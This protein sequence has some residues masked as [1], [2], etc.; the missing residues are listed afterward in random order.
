MEELN[1]FSF[2]KIGESNY[3]DIQKLFL[4]VYGLGPSLS[5]IVEKFNCLSGSLASIGYVAY[6]KVDGVLAALYAIFPAEC[7]VDGTK[8]LC[9][10]SGDTMTHPKYRGN[11]LFTALAK[12]TYLEARLA[13]IKFIFG[14]PNENSYYGFKTKLAWTFPKKTKSSLLPSVNIFRS[15][16]SLNISAPRVKQALSTFF[17]VKT[18]AESV[19][20]FC[21]QKEYYLIRNKEHLM[22]RVDDFVIYTGKHAVW[23]NVNN[24]FLNVGSFVNVEG[25]ASPLLGRHRFALRLFFA[26][27]ICGLRGAR[28]YGTD[29]CIKRFSQLCAYTITKESLSYGYIKLDEVLDGL[30]E[31]E[32]E[33]ADYDTF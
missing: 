16:S 15:Q 9:A 21:E 4:E 7:V 14:F 33:Y 31:M 23:C 8:T 17:H 20:I 13:G 22:G 19:N 11:G 28:F 5:A 6:S 10:Q 32:F 26:L 3:S 18:L 29:E 25:H 12:M 1:K 24:G 2:I 30:D 27:S